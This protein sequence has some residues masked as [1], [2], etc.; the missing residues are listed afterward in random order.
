MAEVTLVKRL[1]WIP[2]PLFAIGVAALAVINPGGAWLPPLLFTGLNVLFITTASL[3]ITALAAVNFWDTREGIMF[4]MGSGAFA[5]GLG[6]LLA[7]FPVSDNAENFLITVFNCSAFLAALSHFIG[8]II[9]SSAGKAKPP[10]QNGPV[11]LTG[12]LG[13]IV[14]VGLIV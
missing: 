1:V 2:V 4:F 11:W 3:L 10:F 12:Y 5:L 9:Y 6:A 7:G 13:V 14:L 8:A